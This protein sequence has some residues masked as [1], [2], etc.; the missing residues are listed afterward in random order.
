MDEQLKEIRRLHSV[1]KEYRE[2]KEELLQAL[3]FMA[4]K[5]QKETTVIMIAAIKNATGQTYKEVFA[6]IE[7]DEN[8]ND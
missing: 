3:I 8:T 7:E 2:E 6:M 5:M 4:K 1:C